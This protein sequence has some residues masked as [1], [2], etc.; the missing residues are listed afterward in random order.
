[1]CR[2][3]KQVYRCEDKQTHRQTETLTNSLEEKLIDDQRTDSGGH[4]DK[5]DE[6]H[7]DGKRTNSRHT[8][9]LE[10]RQT[11]GQRTDTE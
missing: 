10:E 5:Q 3:F 4:T 6:R 9:I 7:T 8:D 1:M 11:D 2:L